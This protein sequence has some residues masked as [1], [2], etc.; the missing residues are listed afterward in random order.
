MKKALVIGNSSYRIDKEKLK[1]PIND[2]KKME[3]ILTYKGFNVTLTSDLNEKDLDGVFNKF[4]D[5]VNEG[6]DVIFF[7]AGHGIEDRD[8]NYLL[9]IDYKENFDL[10]TSL[11]VDKIQNRLYQKNNSGF[12]L[13]VIDACR[14]N[15][16]YADSPLPQK[17]KANNNTLVAFSTSSGNSAK[18][19]NGSNSYYTA[20]LVETIKEYG[21]SISEVFSI[22]RN[23][24][25]EHTKFAQVPWEYGSLQDNDKFTFDNINIPIKLKRII[26]SKSQI[27]YSINNFDDTFFVAG[28]SKYLD[29]FDINSSVVTSLNTYVDES[30]CSIEKL[31][32]NNELLVFISD[33]GH[34]GVF[35]FKTQK[36]STHQYDETFFS[37]AVNNGNLAIVGGRLNQLKVLDLISN[38]MSDID[39]KSEV[40]K[41]ICN[42]KEQLDYLSSEFTIMTSRFS[43]KDSNIVAFGGSNSVFCV[44]NLATGKYLYLNETTELFTYTY[45]IDFSNDGRFAATTHEDGKAILWDANTF[46]LI[47]LFQVNENVKKN[48][49]FEFTD[50]KHSNHLHHVRF[51][52]NSM[53][54]AVST[55]ESEVIFYDITYMTM[56]ARLDLN[57]EALNIYTFEFNSSGDNMVI[58]LNNKNYLFGN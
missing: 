9:S 20:S 29:V 57:I 30:H 21:L 23:K 11:T 16:V 51:L 26:K 55:S 56:I 50:E 1:N 25:I 5:N 6:D 15:P 7:F 24:V 44:K 43:K 34:I 37:I 52:P 14:N 46:E 2:A 47:H 27:S 41:T 28:N 3:S 36:V 48:Q 58:S 54:M 4:V 53:A 40:L 35:N 49:F 10:D 42:N 32:S 19:G 13:I 22:T 8:T 45:C 31:A 17:T 18:D 33:A 38:T 12:K 39:L